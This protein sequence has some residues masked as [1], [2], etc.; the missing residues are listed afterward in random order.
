MCAKKK[1][2]KAS[3]RSN[4]HTLHSMREGR[5]WWASADPSSLY[6]SKLQTTSLGAACR[7]PPSTATSSRTRGTTYPGSIVVRQRQMLRDPAPYQRQGQIVS[8]RQGAVRMCSRSTF[9]H[10]NS[11]CRARRSLRDQ[12]RVTKHVN[13][14]AP[15]GLIP[16]WAKRFSV[17]RVAVCLQPISRPRSGRTRT[18]RYGLHNLPSRTSDLNWIIISRLPWVAPGGTGEFF[19][20][21][22]GHRGGWARHL[23]GVSFVP[24]D[25]PFLEKKEKNMNRCLWPGCISASNSLH[26]DR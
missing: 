24:H 22:H 10:P 19:P 9:H 15:V 5:R 14:V 11:G 17:E 7:R 18:P 25:L 6:G 21:G 20:L 13:L 16:C 1:K 4:G 3:L 23:Q 12:A 26:R 2:C 8:Q